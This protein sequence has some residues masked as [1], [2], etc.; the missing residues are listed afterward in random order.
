MIR[1]LT[2]KLFIESGSFV[3]YMIIVLLYVAKHHWPSLHSELW[4]SIALVLL[5]ICWYLRSPQQS[6]K[7][8]DLWEDYF[9]G[10]LA[11]GT[12]FLAPPPEQLETMERFATFTM[13]N[14]VHF[15]VIWTIIRRP[16]DY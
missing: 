14:V 5:G 3:G 4:P 6:P 9:L 2:H 1:A 13:F 11:G 7:K 16:T 8:Q 10:L 15:Y 12:L